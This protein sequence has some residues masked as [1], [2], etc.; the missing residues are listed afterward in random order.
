M[1][2]FRTLRA[3]VKLPV[4]WSRRWLGTAGSRQATVGQVESLERVV[5]PRQHLDGARVVQVPRARRGRALVEIPQRRL[6]HAGQFHLRPWPA[7]CAEFRTE[8]NVRTGW[9]GLAFFV[10]GENAYASLR[11]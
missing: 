3:G 2:A 8:L 10:P 6:R 1:S 11:G 7:H 4:M 9:A 5:Q